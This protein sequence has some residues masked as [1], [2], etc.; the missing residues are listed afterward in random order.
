MSAAPALGPDPALAPPLRWG[1][2]APGGIARKFARELHRYTSSR[3]V[4]VG[5]R[6]LERAEAFASEFNAGTAYGSYAELVADPRVE[7]VYVCSPHS[8]HREHALLAIEA[9]RHVLVEKAFARNRAEAE[10][11]FT[12]ARLAGV[13]AMEAMW[14]RFLPH[15]RALRDL[16][17]AGA[18]GEITHVYAAHGQPI[19]Q[20]PRMARPDLAGGALLDLGVYPISFTH[21]LLGP[22]EE[23]TS[24]GILTDAGVDANVGVVLTYPNAVAT[25]ST[26]MLARTRNVAEIAGTA[27]TIRVTD[28]FYH[29][30]AR[31]EVTGADGEERVIDPGAEGGFQFEAAAVA[32]AVAAGETASELMS[33]QGTLDVMST[34]DTIRG[35]LGVTF[36]GE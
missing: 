24:A 21:D 30:S 28:T 22:P 31:L 35:Q 3:V 12:A 18:I 29:P 7:A 25:L 23:I 4:A 26:T 5:S 6:S 1:I 13:F 16:V 33:W 34:M 8:H 36:P 20:V 11:V 32:R 2:L 10:E 9:G 15:V 27:G 17:A 19:A 14:T